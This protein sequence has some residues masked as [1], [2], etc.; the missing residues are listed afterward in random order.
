MQKSGT[1]HHNSEKELNLRTKKALHP[2]ET[3]PGSRTDENLLK[4]DRTYFFLQPPFL[5]VFL[6]GT[7]DLNTVEG[8]K[9]R[10]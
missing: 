8:L 4:L 6:A 3:Q 10:V 1:E 5:Q 2:G 7:A 9:E